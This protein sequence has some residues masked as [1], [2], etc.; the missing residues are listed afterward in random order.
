MRLLWLLAVASV[1]QGQGGEFDDFDGVEETGKTQQQHHVVIEEDEMIVEEIEDEIEVVNDQGEL[2][3][4][5][6]KGIENHY[7]IQ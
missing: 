4:D 3:N 6:V 2:L 7:K 5:Q 1:A